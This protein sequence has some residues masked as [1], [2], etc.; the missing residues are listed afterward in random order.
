MNYDEIGKFI[1]TKRKEKN[2]TQKELADKLEIT[3]KAISK[4]E[5][6]QGCPDVSLLEMLSKELDCSIL[7]LLKGRE[8]EEEVIPVTEADD[9][10]REG[11]NYSKMD[12]KSKFKL[13]CSRLIAILIIFIV[14]TLSYLN[15]VQVKYIDKEYTYSADRYNHKKMM[16]YIEIA[17]KN[18]DVIRNNKGRFSTEDYN[19]IL[20]NIDDYYEDINKIK[21]LK[22]IKSR[23]KLT[24]TINDVRL[25]SLTGNYMPYEINTLDILKKYSDNNNISFYRELTIR[26]FF[27]K[28]TAAN[29]TKNKPLL[30]Y[31]YRI[32]SNDFAEEVLGWS[33]KNLQYVVD[34][35]MHEINKL[36]YLTE[37][38]MEVGDINE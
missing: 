36:I 31:Q 6:G 17:D 34:D 37:L 1:Q 18:I 27:N 35:L 29:E 3:D 9:Y 2:L 21:L 28:S 10:I 7:E 15:I 12:L 8:I 30:I 19:E 23:D 20:K 11:I 16:G 33:E 26:S 24:Y 13:I 25:L 4:W 32:S 22:Y 38:V 5:R 14:L